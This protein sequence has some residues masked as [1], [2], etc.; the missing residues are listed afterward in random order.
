MGIQIG[1]IHGTGAAI[2]VSLGYIPDAVQITNVPDGDKI[3]YCVLDKVLVFTRGGEPD[4]KGWMRLN[5]RLL[6]PVRE[7][8]YYTVQVPAGTMWVGRND[9]SICC[10]AELDKPP[11]PMIVHD[12]VM[13]SVTH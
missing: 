2:N 7:D 6:E 13:I 12:E 5:H 10:N 8:G 4:T 1:Y 9:F 11:N 3:H